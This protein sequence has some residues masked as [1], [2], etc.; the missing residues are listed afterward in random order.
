MCGING[1]IK[2][3]IN[4]HD[5]NNVIEMNKV[6]SHRGPDNSEI[7][8]LNDTVFGHTR[9]AIIDLNSRSNQPF[10]KDNLVITFNGEI[11]NYKELKKKTPEATYLT[12]SDTEVILEL[13]R[14][15]KENCLNFLRG[16]FAFA[17]HDIDTKETFLVRDHFGIKPLYYY[18]DSNQI[19]FSSEIKSIKKIVGKKMNISNQAIV[20]SSLYCWIPEKNCIFSDI[21]KLQPGEYIKVKNN[22]I[23]CNQYWSNKSLID[24]KSTLNNLNDAIHKLSATLED[25]IDKHLVSDVPVNAFLS[26]GLDSSLLVAIARQRLDQLDCYNIKFTD[27]DQKH[28]ANA[29]DS[30]YADKVSKYL[31]VKLNTLEVKPN[32]SN[33]LEKI[34]YH[35]DEPIG[36]SAAINTYLICENAKNNGVKVLL[37]GMGSDEIF[38]GYRKHRALQIK[39]KLNFVPSITFKFLEKISQNI[40][41]NSNQKGLKLIRWFK[42]FTNILKYSENNKAFLRSYTYYDIDK[43]DEIFQFNSK[44][45]SNSILKNFNDN[46]SFANNK[47][48]LLDTMNFVDINDFMVSLNLKYTDLASMAS[49][50]E[51]RVPYIDLEVMKIAFQINSKFKIKNNEQKFI[52]KKVAEKWLPKE[53]IYRPKANF[54]LPLRAWIKKDLNSLV[55]E[56]ILS[57]TGIKKR[58]LF[59][60]DFLKK[61]ID[62]EYNNISDNSQKI[63]QLLTL[64]QWFRNNEKDDI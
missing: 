26:G 53:I 30:Y 46:F 10:K 48:D 6:L 1:I 64:E 11:Y 44:D 43:F 22:D 20:A 62:D 32:L 3:N 31:N 55:S 13:W 61:T 16:M 14:K 28:E 45:I 39:S 2:Y 4:K 12:D 9:L 7:W 5:I 23:E 27:I 63:W 41:V 33:L 51:V 37:S 36:D 34:V 40:P 17:I 60:E 25:S 42:R 35:L 47:R 56:Y 19:I 38:S 49:S 52:L 21:K 24:K 29:N 59:K 15:Y 18:S 57:D 54:T 58:N 8:S 50:S